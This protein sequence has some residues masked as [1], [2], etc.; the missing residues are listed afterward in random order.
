[1]NKRMDARTVK[2]QE[3]FSNL[4]DTKTQMNNPGYIREANEFLYRRSLLL[5]AEASRRLQNNGLVYEYGDSDKIY[6][7]SKDVTPWANAIISN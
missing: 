5:S 6:C 2:Q 7:L 1:M 3:L 4:A